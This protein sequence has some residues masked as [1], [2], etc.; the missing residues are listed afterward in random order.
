M[1]ERNELIAMKNASRNPTPR[2][3]EEN[4]A[5]S[6]EEMAAVKKRLGDL[7]KQHIGMAPGPERNA[8]GQEIVKLNDQLNAALPPAVGPSWQRGGISAKAKQKRQGRRG[9]SSG[10]GELE[11]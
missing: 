8:I 5:A 3:L 2:P 7:Q 1:A 9:S 4:Q 10:Q 6:L 11:R